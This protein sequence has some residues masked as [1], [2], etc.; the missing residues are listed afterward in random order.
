MD[1]GFNGFEFDSQDE[2]HQLFHELNRIH[3][4]NR[5]RNARASRTSNNAEIIA[6]LREL[7]YLYNT[8]IRE[9]QDNMRL[10]IQTIYLFTSNVNATNRTVPVNERRNDTGFLYVFPGGNE[11]RATSFN[12]NGCKQ[13]LYG[14]DPSLVFKYGFTTNILLECK[15]LCI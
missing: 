8:N 15:S 7:V 2:L 14:I 11:R 1:N 5:N 13:P 6:L 12:E 9:Y 10:I 4:N 3:I